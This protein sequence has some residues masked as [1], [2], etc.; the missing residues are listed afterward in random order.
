MEPYNSL[1]STSV[2]LE[3]L[4]ASMV[5]DNEAIY[6]ICHRNLDIVRP[7]FSNM[8]GVIAQ[9]VSSITTGSRF[10]GNLN[11][12]LPNLIPYPR[13]NSMLLSYSPIV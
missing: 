9:V 13:I 12:T 7:A 1:L 6:D 4:D 10:N 5:F 11:V 3:H 8:N 2:G